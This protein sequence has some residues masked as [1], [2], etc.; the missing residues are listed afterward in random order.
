KQLLMQEVIEP[1][2]NPETF[3]RYGLTVPNGMLL[4]GPPGCGKTYIAKQLAEELDYS[5]IEV[6]PSEVAGIYIHQSVL[7]IREIF[8]SAE[9][10]A[11]SIVF[12]DEFEAFVPSRAELGATQQHKSEEVNELLVQLSNCAERNIFL[13][14]ATNEPGKIDHAIRRTGRLDKLV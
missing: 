12:I 8:E 2:R 6:I 14:A 4:F 3:K 10:K 11:P 9:E 5:F 7:K 13:I 1:L